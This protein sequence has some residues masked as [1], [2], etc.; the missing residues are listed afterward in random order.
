MALRSQISV[1]RFWPILLLNEIPASDCVTKAGSPVTDTSH[2][3][4]KKIKIKKFTYRTTILVGAQ[5]SFLI[6]LSTTKC[7]P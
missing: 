7:A 1:H 3:V 6:D 5:E 2:D 4:C